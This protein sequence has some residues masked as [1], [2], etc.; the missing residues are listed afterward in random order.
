MMRKSDAGQLRFVI[1][2][3]AQADECRRIRDHQLRVAQSDE[4][5]EHADAARGR[6]LQAVG[7]AVDDLLAD[8]GDGQNQKEQRPKRKIT[9]SAVR[10]G[11]CIPRQTEYVK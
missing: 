1:G 2:E 3:A 9:P 4:R 10:Q 8:A 5:D 7:N 11:T 6:M